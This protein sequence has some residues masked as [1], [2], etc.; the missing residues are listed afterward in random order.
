MEKG[1]APTA[2][3]TSATTWS[4]RSPRLQASACTCRTVQVDACSN[5]RS[6]AG[7]ASLACAV[8]MGRL[9]RR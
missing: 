5:A 3:V 2:G 8:N 6:A 4:D 1:P 9:S 7:A